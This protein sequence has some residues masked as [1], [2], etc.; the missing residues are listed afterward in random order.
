M[1]KFSKKIKS[2]YLLIF[3]MFY[4][5]NPAKAEK[6]EAIEVY[7]NERLADQTIILFSNLSI[8]DNIDSNIINNTFI[9]IV[10]L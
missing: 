2:L 6:I 8:G 7:G 1:K 10:K 9:F 5:F 3:V 4:L